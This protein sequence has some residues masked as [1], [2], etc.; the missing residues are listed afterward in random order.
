MGTTEYNFISNYYKSFSGTDTL[1]FILLP[2]SQPVILGSITTVSYSIYRTKQPVINLGRTNINGATRGARI[3]AGT[4]IFTLINQHWL[5]ELLDEQSKQ[6]NWL[7]QY[8][9]LKADEL[10][11]FDLM[12][13]SANEYGSYVSMFLYGV[14][15]TDEGQVISVE[16]LFTENTLS[17][18][19]RDIQTFKAGKVTGTTK[20]YHSSNTNTINE[21]NFLG[22][23]IANETEFN[24]RVKNLDKEYIK[25]LENKYINK[26][27]EQIENINKKKEFKNHYRNLQYDPVNLMVG[28]DVG[29]IQERLILW[30]FHDSVNYM[31][32]KN[33]EE[34]VRKFQSSKGL[35]QITGVVDYKTYLALTK[36][37][38]N[39]NDITG[40]VINES[41]GRVYSYPNVYSSIVDTK[42]Y[43]TV[44]EIYDKISEK[45]FTD[46][47]TRKVLYESGNSFYKIQ[48][49][50]IN[51]NDVF[52][53]EHS[54]KDIAF[55]TINRGE[56]GP[57][58]NLLQK[59][60]IQLGMTNYTSGIYD[61][62][63]I[64]FIKKIQTENNIACILGIVN[65]E[66]WR[67]IQI[68]TGN[69]MTNIVNNN[70]IIQSQNIQGKYELTSLDINTPLFK[71][72]DVNIYSNKD[73]SIKCC[74]IAY[75]SNNKTKT[76][77]KQ[78]VVKK[79]QEQTI[80]FNNFQNLF[81]YDVKNGYPTKIEYIVYPY[82]GDSYKW[83]INYR[84]E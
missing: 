33:T 65:E 8:Q 1:V 48:E 47:I 53:Y 18:I 38:D 17:F 31:F 39:S 35:E 81:I 80:E 62:K 19:A 28:D 7:S 46:K 6:T 2:G 44:L 58:V 61:E 84:G 36:N 30:N 32:D 45:N 9:E 59:L 4:M 37:P 23:H 56:T 34:A 67:V 75:Y 73:T 50:Y 22:V 72:F 5:N 13:V 79:Q 66:T 51:I 40:I 49:G 52:S 77:T 64:R 68:L 76:I 21:I 82:N 26:T 24:E 14:D 15:I 83:I 60:L 78:F 55:P 12:I 70:I 42:P 27:K 57:Y 71:G 63:T 74:A 11:L 69:I 43:N 10:P 20:I 41:G 25:T 54:N 3:Y 29:Y 16:D